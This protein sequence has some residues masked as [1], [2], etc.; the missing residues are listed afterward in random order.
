MTC[1]SKQQQKEVQ[2]YDATRLNFKE[3]EKWSLFLLKCYNLDTLGKFYWMILPFLYMNVLHWLGP[4]MAHYY[5]RIILCRFDKWCIEYY[6]FH[7]K[8]MAIK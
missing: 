7:K 5:C 8:T 6:N 4:G 2:S 3:K 1:Q